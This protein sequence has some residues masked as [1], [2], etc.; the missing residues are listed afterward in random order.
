MTPADFLDYIFNSSIF[1]PIVVPPSELEEFESMKTVSLVLSQIN[2]T[3]GKC[4]FF[5]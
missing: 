4:C 3:T 5:F 2:I 1:S